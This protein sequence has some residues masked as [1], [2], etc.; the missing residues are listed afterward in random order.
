[1]NII[2]HTILHTSTYNFITL[3]KYRLY[4]KSLAPSF[5]GEFRRSVRDLT[6][7]LG[8]RSNTTILAEY[9]EYSIVRATKR[10]RVTHLPLRRR[11]K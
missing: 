10:R 11:K 5:K 4:S 8:A 6:E 9:A 1:M 7:E 2:L 3:K